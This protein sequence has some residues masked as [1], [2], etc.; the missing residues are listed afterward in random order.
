[1]VRGEG[2][3]RKAKECHDTGD[4]RGGNN[5]DEELAAVPGDRKQ[6]KQQAQEQEEGA[7]G[8]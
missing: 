2:V 7:E 3:G 4:K 5:E 6:A 8:G 1:M